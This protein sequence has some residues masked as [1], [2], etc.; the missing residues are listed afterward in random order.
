VI[1]HK[2]TCCL[3]DC[4]LEPALAV[5]NDRLTEARDPQKHATTYLALVFMTL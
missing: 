5:W 3:F 4:P 1:R 2:E